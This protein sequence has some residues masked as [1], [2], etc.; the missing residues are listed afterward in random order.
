VSR[1]DESQITV[2][3]C[4]VRL[5]RAGGGPPL[6]FL[7]GASGANWLPALDDLAEGFDVIA[8]EHPGF[9]GSDV[10]DWLDNIHDLAYYY[11]DFVR[12]LGLDRVHLVGISLGGWIAAEM[13]VRSTR[14]LASLTLV[15]AAGL[16]VNG[17]AQMDPFLCSDEER[18]RGYFHDPALA[19]PLIARLLTPEQEDVNLKNRA[20]TARLSW[21]PRGHDPHLHKWLHLIDVPTLLVWG[22]DDR[23]F[24]AR[25]GAEFERL[26][27]G[28][29]L[30]VLPECGHVPPLE[31]QD[32]FVDAV[33]GF[34]ARSAS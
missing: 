32:A 13:A 27:P 23:M 31:K 15:S 4:S 14:H 33:R 28:A 24:P 34:I 19:E 29:E 20:T 5:M 16:H 17:V 6:L 9:G 30:V 12:A 22:D 3:D 7:H 10:P 11:V 25:L 8:P 1:H 26:I 21:Q 18:L 2:G